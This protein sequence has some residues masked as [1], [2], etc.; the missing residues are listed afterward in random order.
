MV[1]KKSLLQKLEVEDLVA[2]FILGAGFVLIALGLD[3]EVKA[4]MGMVAG[5]YFRGKVIK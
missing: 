2:F 1:K 4:L 5:F 3:G